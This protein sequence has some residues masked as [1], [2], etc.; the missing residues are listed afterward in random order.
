MNR[1]I[2]QSLEPSSIPKRTHKQQILCDAIEQNYQTLEHTIQVYV[3]R[4]IK[5]FGNKFDLSCDLDSI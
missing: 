2:K 4:V 5:Q 3:S 1:Q